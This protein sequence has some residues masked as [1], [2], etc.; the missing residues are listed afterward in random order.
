MINVVQHPSASLTP[1]L[2]KCI[3]RSRDQRSKKYEQYNQTILCL[4]LS[5]DD[6][7]L[8]LENQ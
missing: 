8:I 3:I 1:E 6:Y 7:L 4:L 2:S 5:H